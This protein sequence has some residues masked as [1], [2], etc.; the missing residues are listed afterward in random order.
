MTQE[1]HNILIENNIMLKQILAYIRRRDGPDEAK[2]FVMNVV[3]NVI[4][5]QLDKIK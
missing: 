5:N 1:E 4:S 2:D 3:A